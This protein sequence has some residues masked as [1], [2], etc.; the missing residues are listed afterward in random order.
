MIRLTLHP[1]PEGSCNM[2]DIVY[3][4]YCVVEGCDDFYIGHT[5]YI[6]M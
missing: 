6:Y 2:E 3:S 5:K 4:V 1:D